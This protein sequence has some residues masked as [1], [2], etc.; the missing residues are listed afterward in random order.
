VKCTC[1]LWGGC[2]AQVAQHISAGMVVY[3]E[4]L[5]RWLSFKKPARDTDGGIDK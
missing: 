5:A 4:P 3:P 2:Q 1:L